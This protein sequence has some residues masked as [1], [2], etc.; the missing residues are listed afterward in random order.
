MMLVRRVMGGLVWR[1][2]GGVGAVGVAVVVV[3]AVTAH[4]LK[5]VV[6][7]FTFMFLLA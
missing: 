5:L 6:D 1:C 2:G 3:M 7:M 4:S